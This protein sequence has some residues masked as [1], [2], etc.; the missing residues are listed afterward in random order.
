MMRKRIVAVLLAVLC[1]C[2]AGEAF[3]MDP[4]NLK[5]DCTI[6]LHAVYGELPIP[7]ATFKAYRVAD[8]SELASYTLTE[9]FAASGA[10]VNSL[11]TVEAMTAASEAFAAFLEDS[12]ATQ[13]AT[14]VTDDTGTVTFEGLT[15][16]LYMIVGDDFQLGNYIYSFLPSMIP[17][18]HI[19][20]SDVWQYESD[21]MVKISRRDVEMDLEIYKVWEDGNNTTYR[22]NEIKINVL[23]D[24]E[25]AYR[26]TLNEANGWHATLTGLSCVH[27]WTVQEPNVPTYYEVDYD[28]KKEGQILIVNELTPP[29]TTPPDIPQTGMVWWPVLLLAGVGLILFLSGWVMHHQWRKGQKK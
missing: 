16:G 19:D 17:V 21:S 22:P 5:Q 10:N 9:D 8:V 26:L 14:A 24:G 28:Y 7:G 25:I 27:E 2:L 15:P 3:A 18:P 23:C 6:V 20:D 12:S 4:I 11:T 29:S 13:T 1:L